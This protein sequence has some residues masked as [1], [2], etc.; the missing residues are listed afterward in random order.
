MRFLCLHGQGTNGMVGQLPA[1]TFQIRHGTKT[2]KVLESQ[3]GKEISI[4]AHSH[5]KADGMLMQ[6]LSDTSLGM[7]TLMNISMVQ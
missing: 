1:Q 7:I 6:R 5:A 2:V 4:F 3:L